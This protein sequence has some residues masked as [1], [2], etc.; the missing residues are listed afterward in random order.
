MKTIHGGLATVGLAIMLLGC[1]SKE[2][3]NTA[4]KLKLDSLNT[5]LSASQDIALQMKEVDELIDSIDDSRQVLRANTV[6]GTSYD[7]YSNRLRE[8]N[9][10]VKNTNEKIAALEKSA[11]GSK[12]MSASI[13][14]L[15]ADLE[16]RTQ[17]I[18]ALQMEVSKMRTENLSMSTAIAQKDSTLLAKEDVIKLREQDIATFENTLKD[19]NEKNQVALANL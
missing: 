9:R 2:K 12:G 6:E 1:N 16:L 19:T 7:N 15:K 14:R 13:R 4:L 18:A 3:E 17:E 5:E 10:Y 8:I 11:K